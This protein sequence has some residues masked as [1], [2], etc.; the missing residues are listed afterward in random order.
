MSSKQWRDV[1]AIYQIYPRSFMDSNDDGVGDLRGV[2]DKLDYIH[3]N[4]DS[5]GIDAIWFSPMFPS[6][7]ADMGYDVSDYCGVDPLFGTLDDFTELV[8][9]AHEKEINVMIDFV[10]NHTSNQHPWFLESKQNQNSD[11]K[12]YYVWQNAKPDGSVPNNWLSIFGGSA[13]EWDEQRGQYYLHTFLKQQPD[14]NWD[15]PMVR[16]EM[17]RVIRFWMDLGVD[18]IRADAVRWIS[19]DPLFR[20]DPKNTAWRNKKAPNQFDSLIHKYSRFWNNLFPYLREMTD[21]I[22]EYDNRIMIFEDYPDDNYNTKEQY[23]GFYGINPK[24]SMPFNFEGLWTDFSADA[25]RDFVTEFQ[26]MLKPDE[27]T[28]VYCFSNH[29]QSRIVTRMGGE[30]QARLIA[31]MQMTLPGLP[32]VYYG[33]ELGM[34]N[35][36]I[37]HDQIRDLSAFSSGDDAASRD[38]ERTPM[39]WERGR[40]AGFSQTKPWLPIGIS[41]SKH[42][43]E[44]QLHEPDSFLS[45]Y[46]R[47][48]KIR[49]RHEILRYGTYEALGEPGSKIFLYSR[50]IEDQHVYIALNFDNSPTTIQLPHK[51]RV[52]CCTHPV[53]Y[54]EVDSEGVVSLRPYEGILVECCEHP[55]SEKCG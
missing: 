32:T 18:G 9:K 25:F 50:W 27:H 12:D 39:Q 41:V 48:L 21:I 47:L 24:V 15:N 55:L 5:L 11:K 26:G 36:P 43:V 29:D 2:I 49:S 20:D 33:D 37:A 31:L 53:D 28:P 22:A 14:L 38:P 23:L 45:L 17:K 16:D 6:P 3:G 35:T 4:K 44:T 54:P 46:R 10:P 30:D 1:N 42:N 51:G 34:P 8:V 52:L 19:K 13:W 40:Y 7:M